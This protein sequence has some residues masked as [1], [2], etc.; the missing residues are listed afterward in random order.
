MMF[1]D[2]KAH[3]GWT[4]FHLPQSLFSLSTLMKISQGQIRQKVKQ[5]K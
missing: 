4:I 3:P 2:Q 1:L 5:M